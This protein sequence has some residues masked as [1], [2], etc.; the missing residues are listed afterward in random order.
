MQLGAAANKVTQ[1]KPRRLRRWCRLCEMPMS[2]VLLHLACINASRG[3][4]KSRSPGEILAT[5]QKFTSAES[6]L[7]APRSPQRHL[8]KLCRE[9]QS[10]VIYDITYLRHNRSKKF[11]S[12]IRVHSRLTV[13]SEYNITRFVLLDRILKLNNRRLHR[14]KL[15][16]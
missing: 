2:E 10:Y 4:T 7:I 12:I 13:R 15:P 3:V 1:R 11:A 16:W 14:G 5:A 6:V 9:R 8:A